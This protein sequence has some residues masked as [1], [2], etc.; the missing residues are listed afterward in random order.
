M[1]ATCSSRVNWVVN[2]KSYT[3]DNAALLL[4][5]ES[6]SGYAKPCVS[7]C[8]EVHWHTCFGSATDALGKALEIGFKFGEIDGRC[9]TAK[10]CVAEVQAIINLINVL[11]SFVN[12]HTVPK[13]G[14]SSSD[15]AKFMLSGNS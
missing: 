1:G 5:S 7:C 8:P 4:C 2:N 12:S 13:C 6:K 3:K 14:G 15:C 9:G 10:S 11:G